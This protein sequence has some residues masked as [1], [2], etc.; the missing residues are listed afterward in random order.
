MRSAVAAEL[1]DKVHIS[2][3][4]RAIDLDFAFRTGRRENEGGKEF[5]MVPRVYLLPSYFYRRY[6]IYYFDL[7]LSDCIR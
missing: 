6:K 4:S 7:T 3:T 2:W 1:R 5:L